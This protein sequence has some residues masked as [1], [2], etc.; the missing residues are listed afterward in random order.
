MGLKRAYQDVSHIQGVALQM[1]LSSPESNLEGRMSSGEIKQKQ[2]LVIP[3]SIL[4]MKIQAH[5]K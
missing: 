4:H 2:L 3:N 5:N 1:S